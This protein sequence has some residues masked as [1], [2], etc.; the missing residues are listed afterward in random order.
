MAFHAELLPE[1]PWHSL[2]P[3]RARAAEHPGGA[4]DL[5][6]GTPADS[7]PGFVREALAEASDAHGYPDTLGTPELREAIRRFLEA[8]RGLAPEAEAGILPTIGS[9]EMVGLLP[10]LLGLGAGATVAF[11][12]AAY[13][14]YDVGARLA[15]CSTL[16]VDTG[17]DPASWADGI[18]LL[19]LNSPG[20]PD[21]HVLGVDQL[22]AI[23]A[24]A[25]ENEVIVAS[26]ECYESLCW[27]VDEAPSILDRRVNGGD[28]AGLLQVYSL[29]KRSNLAGYRASFLAGDPALLAPITELRRHLGFMMPGPVQHAMAAAL[30]DSAHAEAQRQVYAERRAKLLE[31]I[32]AAGLAN[33]PD[34]VAGL[35]LWVRWAGSEDVTGWDIVNSCAELGIVVTPG[36]FYGEAARGHARI[37]LTAPDE[38]IA[39]AARRLPQLRGLLG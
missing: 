36:D 10:S 3:A 30:A 28:L 37:S 16:C 33:D 26:D 32:E 2:G 34:S 8:E 29:S 18:D 7:V 9:K 25:R 6:I 20:N 22:R 31:A 35:Y 39:E 11:P 27:E 13:P 23:V 15:G 17:A 1:F 21:G 38:A 5:T 12:A 19:W 14:T 4:V 24:W